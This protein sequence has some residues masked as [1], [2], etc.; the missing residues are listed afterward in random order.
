[1]TATLN[2]MTDGERLVRCLTGG[3]VDRVPFGCGL[4]W[5]PWHEAHVNFEAGWR[6]EGNTGEFDYRA[7][8]GF[9]R[10]FA[11]APFDVG[12]FPRF[13]HTVIKDTPESCTWRD[14]RGITMR[15]VKG[16]ASM[17]EYLDYPVK[18]PDD[19]DRFK[20]ERFNLGAASIDARL[21]SREADLRAF[22]GY[23]KT[24]GAAAQIG[25]FPYGAFGCVRDFMGD[26][27]VLL[28]F[29]TEPEMV[30]DMMLTVA[31]LWLAVYERT[32]D[33]LA[34]DGVKVDH[35]HIWED[36]SGR[37]GSLI[38]PAMVEEFM[39]PAYD[40][41]AD[42]CR[43]RGIRVMSVDSDGDC[44]E[45]VPVMMRHGVNMFLPFEVM[46]DHDVRDYR[47]L[48]PTLGIM[49]GLDKFAMDRGEAAVDAQIALAAEMIRHGRYVP[50]FDH[51]V[52]PCK[53]EL[54]KRAA[55][56]IRRACLN[57]N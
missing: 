11:T 56:G 44:R 35:F 57:P 4:G 31:R 46:A 16:S 21:A 29:Y 32:C 15:S 17:P 37:T 22:A 52:P 51:H 50:C 8:F 9:D 33:S 39:M 47:R 25:V 38:S 36:M 40:M 42:F 1:M 7:A 3:D 10:D 23:I 27:E 54:F 2:T 53:Y 34:R 30:K 43:A 48:Y 55:D 19:W 24:S 20:S 41:V 18:T 12:P 5:H 6:A 14:Q 13:E 45:L 26:E 49:G 28:A